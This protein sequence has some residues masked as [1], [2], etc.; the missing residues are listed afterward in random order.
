MRTGPV[1]ALD[2]QTEGARLTAGFHLSEDQQAV[3]RLKRL[4]ERSVPLLELCTKRGIFRGPIFKRIYAT[5]SDYG[6]PYVSARDL[7][8]AEIRPTSFLSRTHGGLLDE[9]KLEQGMILVTCSGMNLGD[10]IWVQGDLSSFCATH[11]LIRVCPN[12]DRI[13]GGYLFSFLRGRYGHAWIRKQIYGGNIKHIEPTHIASLPVPRLSSQMETRVHELVDESSR[14]LNG[15][16]R[17]I[18]AATDV[19]FSTVGLSDIATSE[20]H[21]SGPDLGFSSRFPRADSFRALN[22]NPRFEALCQSIQR[23]PW[24]P[25]GRIC[26]PGTLKRGGRFK[27]VDAERDFGIQLVGQK[28]LFWLR[29]RGRWVSK[30]EVGENLLVAPG[31]TLVAAQGTLGESELFCRSEFAW[32]PG[33]DLAYSEHILRVVADESIMLR[34]ALFA[35]MRSETAFR[36]LRSISVGTK[37]QDHHYA[38]RPELP[39]PYP[40]RD[41]QALIHDLVT[42]AY[43]ARFRAVALKDR[44]TA[45][46]ERAI[47]EAA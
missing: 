47:E 20:W 11:D 43:D 1:S 15:Y 7:M 12:S 19:L 37:L 35:F 36:M 21:S 33:L 24:K 42:S 23:G 17:D 29:P 13:P 31:T 44:A 8:Q 5:N 34:G 3:A 39:V 2:L 10:A 16:R 41:T 26:L 25:L 9:L 14:L 4:A 27:R 46:V 28:R 30:A 45:I 32:G 38:F 6:V 40:S 22:F 18:A